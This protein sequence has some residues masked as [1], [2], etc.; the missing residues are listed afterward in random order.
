MEVEQQ[1]KIY[2]VSRDIRARNVNNKEEDRRA[3][4]VNPGAEKHGGEGTAGGIRGRTRAA[5]DKQREAWGGTTVE[6][7]A[8]EY[9]PGRRRWEVAA[10]TREKGK[11]LGKLATVMGTV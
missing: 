2:R 10:A 3:E 5:V 4:S 1:R 6:F 11:Y 9:L 7:D 8:P